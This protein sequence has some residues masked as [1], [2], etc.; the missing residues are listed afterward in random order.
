MGCGMITADQAPIVAEYSEPC[1]VFLSFIRVD[2][3]MSHYELL[4]GL[5]KGRI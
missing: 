5:S 1:L 2:S 4:T 3:D